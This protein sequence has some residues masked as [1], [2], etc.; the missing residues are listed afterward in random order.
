MSGQWSLNDLP[1][2]SVFFPRVNWLESVA[3]WEVEK[4][5]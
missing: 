3:V 2:R 5:L 4:P 1:S